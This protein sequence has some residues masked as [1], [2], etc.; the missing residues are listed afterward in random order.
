MNSVSDVMHKVALG[1]YGASRFLRRI[2]AGVE[3]VE[4]AIGQGQYGVAAYMARTV[5]LFCLSVRSLA[6]GGRIDLDEESVFFDYFDALPADEVALAI[7][8]AAQAVD[9]D[10]ARAEDWLARFHGYVVET[11]HLLG[12][13]DA[14]PLLRSAE[15]GLGLI[16]LL[17]RW[18]PRLEELGMP[19][20]LPSHWIA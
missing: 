11:Q 5:I 6:R 8:L 16:R 17:R 20:L 12:D 15:G 2:Q 18:G 7:T 4:G 19:S 14:L 9:L 13:D 1:A 3:D 10:A